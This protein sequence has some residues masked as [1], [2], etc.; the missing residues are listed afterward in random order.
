MQQ[1]LPSQTRSAYLILSAHVSTAVQQQCV[2]LR[3]AAERGKVQQRHLG[4]ASS[5]AG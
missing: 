1:P 5:R 4:L 2:T 3:L